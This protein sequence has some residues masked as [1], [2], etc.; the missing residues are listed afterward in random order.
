MKLVRNSEYFKPI[1]EKIEEKNISN[2]NFPR[3]LAR[4][5]YKNFIMSNYYITVILLKS[6]WG[7]ILFFFTIAAFQ[8]GRAF[9][10]QLLYFFYK[11]HSSLSL[12]FFKGGS[13]QR[14][15]RSKL[16]NKLF[17]NFMAINKNVIKVSL[18][19]IKITTPPPFYQAL[20]ST[21]LPKIL[22][23]LPKYRLIFPHFYLG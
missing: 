8:R 16:K 11:H 18:L 5:L 6:P 2:N 17:R 22:N 14:E 10:K 12:F 19:F 9:Y 3:I 1:L 13:F 15:G 23:I 4:F 7:F 21:V 20:E